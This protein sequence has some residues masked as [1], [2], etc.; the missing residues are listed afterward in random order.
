[1]RNRKKFYYKGVETNI[2]GIPT[3][4]LS[5][6]KYEKRKIPRRIYLR[7]FSVDIKKDAPKNLLLIYDIPEGKKKERDWF[8]RQLKNF[9]FVMIQR[10][11]WVGPS[12]L[13]PSFINYLKRI[14]LDKEFKTFNLAKPYH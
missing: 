1:M 6:K 13:P 9:D 10:S 4:I 2:F 7:S 12:P 14:H 11:V 3:A 5:K 8:R